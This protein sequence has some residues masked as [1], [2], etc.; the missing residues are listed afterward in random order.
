MMHRVLLRSLRWLPILYLMAATDASACAV[1]GIATE[2]SRKSFIY[3]TALLSL[4][5]L[6]MIGALIYYLYR[7]NQRKQ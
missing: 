1:C 2:A 6:A 4:A 3:S 5:P 7:A